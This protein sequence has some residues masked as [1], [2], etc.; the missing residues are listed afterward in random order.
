MIDAVL[1]TGTDIFTLLAVLF[2]AFLGFFFVAIIVV[3]L[4]GILLAIYFIVI[5]KPVIE[6][7]GSWRLERAKG[8]D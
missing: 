4:V 2:I 5:K 1:E 7:R 6:H 3:V 8:K